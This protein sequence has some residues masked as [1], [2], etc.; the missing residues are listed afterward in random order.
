VNNKKEIIMNYSIPA[1]LE[2]LKKRMCKEGS[3]YFSEAN[4]AMHQTTHVEF[5][6][7][8]KPTEVDYTM[9]IWRSDR[10][11]LLIGFYVEAGYD[12]FPT[13][14]LATEVI[15]IRGVYLMTWRERGIDKSTCE[16]GGRPLKEI[17]KASSSIPDMVR[18]ANNMVQEEEGKIR[19]DKE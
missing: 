13:D 11:Y 5:L 2:E 6:P 4:M 19:G 1:N 12:M 8:S 16:I 17:K 14:P 18:I 10:K 7:L 15:W 3:R 9:P